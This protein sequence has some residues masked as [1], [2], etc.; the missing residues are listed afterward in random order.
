MKPLYVLSDT[1]RTELKNNDLENDNDVMALKE[2]FR[3]RRKKIENG[4]EMCLKRARDIAYECRDEI[5]KQ[6]DSLAD[7]VIRILEQREA[8]TANQMVSEANSKRKKL[9]MEYGDR[10]AE[11]VK[12]SME[13]ID[14]DLTQYENSYFIRQLNTNIKVRLTDASAE[15]N[16]VLW[17][18]LADKDFGDTIKSNFYDP[19]AK[20]VGSV[21]QLAQFGGQAADE[22]VGMLLPGLVKTGPQGLGGMIMNIFRSEPTMLEK[23]GAL[24]ARN[25]GKI[26]GVVGMAATVY[27][28]AKQDENMKKAAQEKNRVREEIRE[29][30]NEIGNEVCEGLMEN[31]AKYAGDILNPAIE[32]CIS[33]I[34]A[35]D[36]A[37]ER[38]RMIDVRLQELLKETGLLMEKLEADYG[39]VKG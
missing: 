28:Q 3:Q 15:D 9:I 38:G 20:A 8:D 12:N 10:L 1:I 5:S 39:Q 36:E 14:E 27:M 23:G 16:A 22:L 11:S 17:R 19:N 31:I 29:R 2:S 32:K 33:Q 25:A 6:G 34:K 7:E 24:L 37:A 13:E 21:P 18:L 35:I 4:K 30:S 26:V